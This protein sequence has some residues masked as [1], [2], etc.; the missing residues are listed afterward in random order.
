MR[1]KIDIKIKLLERNERGYIKTK[2]STSNWGGINLE[3]SQ[4]GVKKT[5]PRPVKKGGKGGC[6]RNNDEKVAVIEDRRQDQSVHSV[7]KGKITP[8]DGSH[9]EAQQPTR[10]WKGRREKSIR[11]RLK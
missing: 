4:S 1:K 9:K 5:R 8:Q 2:L 10:G 11:G 7:Q 3:E 6:K